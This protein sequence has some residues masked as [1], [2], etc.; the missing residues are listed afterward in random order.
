[1]CAVSLAV[2]G[3]MQAPRTSLAIGS[4]YYV[5]C[6]SGNDN[7]SGRTKALAWKTISRVNQAA[8]APGDTVLLKRKCQWTGPLNAKWHGTETAPIT[9]GAYGKG[10]FP[11][12]INAHDNIWVTGSYLVFRKL[13]TRSD[14]IGFDTACENVPMGWQVGWRFLNGSHHNVVVNAQARDLYMGVL[15]E[16]GSHDNKI[17]R[18][19]F[20]DINVKDDNPAS[21]A[22]AMAIAVEG[23]RNEIAY[24]VITGSDTCSRFYERDGAAV[25]IHGGQDN[26]VHHNVAREN[27]N[28]I[29]LGNSRTANTTVAYNVV[30]SSLKIA[31]FI[32]ARGSGDRWGPTRG[33]NVYNN[34]IYLTGAESFAVLCSYGCDSSI[35]TF[36]NNIVYSNYRVG[37]VDGAWAEGNNI[38]WS[39]GGPRIW[40]P[41]SSS[42]KAVNP[43]FADPAHGD[44]RLTG[45]SPAVDAGVVVYG[46]YG[47]DLDG[48][49]VPQGAKVDIGAY[50]FRR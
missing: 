18:S 8:L 12:I 13:L 26:A 34:S 19:Q 7:A 41:M 25:E 16:S 20:T 15:I 14:P 6:N 50:E 1:M 36:R 37:F 32:V 47:T 38:W 11:Q 40:F 17:L 43:G 27:N 31:N 49:A 46:P 22:G 28:F 42:S 24:N 23:D 9:I 44:F 10:A 48:V 45:S 21:D 35:M 29:E 3:V 33:T 30:S 5:N 39:P 2:M 4:T